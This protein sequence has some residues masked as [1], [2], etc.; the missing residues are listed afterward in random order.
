MFIRYFAD[1]AMNVVKSEKKPRRNIQYKDLGKP[2]L[3][4]E[5]THTDESK[6]NAVSR[7]D[8]L[9]F[10]EDIVPKTTTYKEYKS[11]KARMN[12]DNGPLQNGQTTLDVPRPNPRHLVSIGGSA[13]ATNDD[14]L[15]RPMTAE[16]QTVQ[17]SPTQPHMSNGRQLI[18]E[19]YEPNGNG[20]RDELGDIDMG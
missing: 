14:N 5:Q 6:A 3:L 4:L 9:S 11:R 16:E 17:Q 8:N 18:F 1:Q 20:R 13:A 15:E 10:L 19:H 2:A 7:I 12:Q